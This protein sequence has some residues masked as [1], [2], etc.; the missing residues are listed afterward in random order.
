[1]GNQQSNAGAAQFFAAAA[2][3][4]TQPLNQVTQTVGL[5]QLNIPSASAAVAASSDPNVNPNAKPESGATFTKVAATSQP[6]KT[7]PPP[8]QPQPNKPPGTDYDINKPPP[9]PTGPQPNADKVVPNTNPTNSIPTGNKQPFGGTQQMGSYQSPIIIPAPPSA[10][11]IVPAMDDMTLLLIA[12]G[13]A[14]FAIL[15]ARK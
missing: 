3:A 7:Q 10:K 11:E 14:A 6:P 5:S 12:G 9:E 2:D 13:T 4:I 15:M 8:T 1:M